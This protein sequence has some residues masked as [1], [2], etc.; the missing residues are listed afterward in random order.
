MIRRREFAMAGVSAAAVAA[1]EAAG[2]AED[3][4]RE[5]GHGLDDVFARCAEAC[6]DCQRE[7]DHCAT[8]CAESMAKGMKHHLAPL[9]AC[10]DCADFCSAAAEI[11]ARQGHFAD[12]VCEG[13]AE[14]CARCAKACEEHGRDDKVMQ[15]CAEECRKCERECRAMLSHVD[16]KI[17]R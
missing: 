15:R 4:R 3:R 2:F 11:I 6:S 7:C 14:A 13:C 12:L 5:P 17:E 8:H 9:M 10:R 1:L 16:R